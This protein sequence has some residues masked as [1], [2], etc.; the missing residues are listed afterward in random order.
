MAMSIRHIWNQSSYSDHAIVSLKVNFETIDRGQG[1]FKGPSELP[2]D[3][4]YQSII[5]STITNCSIEEQPES[6]ARKE[7][8]ETIEGKI[9]IEFTLASHRQDL[10]R[11]GFEAM[12]RFL[13]S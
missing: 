11:V 12:E 5:K 1:I 9:K 7:L 2:M 10:S 6:D 8:M 4:N 3:M 13:L